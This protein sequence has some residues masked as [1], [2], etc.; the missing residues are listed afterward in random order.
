MGE[1]QEEVMSDDEDNPVRQ[2]VLWNP[3]TGKKDLKTW[4]CP[5]CHDEPA[6]QHFEPEPV[7]RMPGRRGGC[8][9][10]ETRN[11]GR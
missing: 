10:C 8:E 7:W 9:V 11:S 5:E 2:Y 4:L 6:M 3:A 1:N